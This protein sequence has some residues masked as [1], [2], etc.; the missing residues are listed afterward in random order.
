MLNIIRI[1]KYD[2][3]LKKYLGTNKFSISRLEDIVIKLQNQ[4]PLDK[5]FNDHQLK[6]KLS[7]Q[8]ECHVYPDILLI[9]E[10]IEDKLILV[11]INLGSHSELF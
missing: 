8:R 9:Y 6:G 5:K 3:S 4:V 10:I 1:K 7:S 2:K 11:L